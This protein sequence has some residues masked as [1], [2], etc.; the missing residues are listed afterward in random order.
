[1]GTNQTL[2]II[3]PAY[4]EARYIGEL[5]ALVQA[6]DLSEFDLGK[7]IIVIDDCS[8]DETA[9]IVCGIDDVRLIS[10]EENRGK[11][12]AVRRGLDAATGDYIIIQDADLEYDPKDYLVM[13]Q[14]LG[15][16]VNVVYGSRYL[17]GNG[18]TWLT[19][20]I[21]AKNKNQSWKAYLGGRS[22]S[23]A[24][25]LF[26][27]VF[28]TDTVTALKLFRSDVL[29]PF[30]FVTDGFELDHEITSKVLGSRHHIEE[31]PI[32]YFPRTKEEGK[33][34]G[35]SDWYTALKT[36]YRFGVKSK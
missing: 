13:L 35:F 25:L 1:M 12:S 32:K 4:N 36:F 34:I 26:T 27:G 31:V 6:V 10:Q 29:E 24:C 30:S 20:L 22:I 19:R 23:I 2:S 9:S 21:D 5:L 3:I 17:H 33:K 11:G 8:T 16:G 14:A 15:D 18:S 7:E 28:L